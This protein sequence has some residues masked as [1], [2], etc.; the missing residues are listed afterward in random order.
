MKKDIGAIITLAALFIMGGCEST[1]SNDRAP[2]TDPR[3]ELM[4][5]W[6]S[7][8]DPE[9]GITEQFLIID[10]DFYFSRPSCRFGEVEQDTQKLGP[11]DQNLTYQLEERNGSVRFYEFEVID[12]NVLSW[13]SVYNDEGILIFAGLALYEERVPAISDSCSLED[14]EVELMDIVVP[15]MIVGEPL[16]INFDYR[17]RISGTEDAVVRAVVRLEKLGDSLHEE[18]FTIEQNP[19]LDGNIVTGFAEVTVEGS[20]VTEADLV[21]VCVGAVYE[22]FTR[23]SCK[24]IEQN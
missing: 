22:A 8:F 24:L 4:G 16:N 13:L 20:A 10:E 3:A 5:H 18:E 17:Y 23:S 9:T 12:G 1:D 6:L 14:V 19:D 11:I 7:P 2:V 15:A 21:E